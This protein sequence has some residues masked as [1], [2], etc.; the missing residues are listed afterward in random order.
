MEAQIN[1]AAQEVVK[2]Q[3]SGSP[4]DWKPPGRAFVAGA[5]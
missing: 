3:N 2:A 1:A 4:A 5:V